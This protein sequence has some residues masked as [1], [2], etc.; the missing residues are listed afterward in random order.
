MK[1]L[2][3]PQASMLYGNGYQLID[4]YNNSYDIVSL[5]KTNAGSR[6]LQIC[7]DNLILGIKYNKIGRDY[8]IIVR[9]N[10]AIT[11]PLEDGTIPILE[12]A[13]IYDNTCLWKLEHENAKSGTDIFYADNN[14][15]F[16]CENYGHPARYTD[17][18]KIY[19]YLESKHFQLD[20]PDE[21]CVSMEEIN[22]KK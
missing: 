7:N 18:Y 21:I 12:C 20:L 14:L 8:K 6:M 4:K 13:K 17:S 16:Y 19:K 5:Y 11:K 22:I 1:T 9:K 15:D 3:L 2:T 10:D